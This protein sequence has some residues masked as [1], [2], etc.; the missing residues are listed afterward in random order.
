MI[1]GRFP[2]LVTV[3]RIVATDNRSDLACRLSAVSFHLFD[4]TFTTTRV[5]VTTIHETVNESVVDAIFLRN[6]A[7][8]VQVIQ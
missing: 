1:V 7:K 4:E 5:S 2:T 3:H 6:I 8:F